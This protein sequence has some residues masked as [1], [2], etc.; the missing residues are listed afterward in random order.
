VNVHPNGHQPRKFAEMRNRI[1]RYEVVAVLPGG[2][3]RLGF[4]ARPSEHRFL[5]MARAESALIL[6]HVAESDCCSYTAAGGLR[7][8]AT[9]TVRKSGRTEHDAAVDALTER[10]PY[11]QETTAPVMQLEIGK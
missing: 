8:S 1:T 11:C 4:T 9:A 2:L 6:P 7:F 3:Y 10:K 5:E